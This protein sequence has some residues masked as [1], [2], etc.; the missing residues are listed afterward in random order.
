MS[1]FTKNLNLKEGEVLVKVVR[2]SPWAFLGSEILVTLLIITPFFFLFLLF[3]WGKQ[4]QIIFFASLILG[5]FLA[6]KT[7]IKWYFNA[8]IITNKRIV[9][10]DQR[11]LFQ[12]TVSELPLN[13]IQDIFYEIKGVKQTIFGYGTIEIIISGT[14]SKLRIRNVSQPQK[15]QQLILQLQTDFLKN[16][17][18]YTKLSAQELVQLV[19]KIK[20]SLGEEKFK[21]ILKEE[22]ETEKKRKREEEIKNWMNE[23]SK[24]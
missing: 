1:K 10:F 21:E 9:D 19:K 5:I 18:E 7:F 13:K 17:I 11:G 8:F 16:T 2:Q 6:F 20:T 24:L 3:S 23:K 4:G 15:I 14:Q 22:E 12:R